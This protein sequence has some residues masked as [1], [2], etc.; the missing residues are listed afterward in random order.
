MPMNKPDGKPAIIMFA[1]PKKK[2]VIAPPS[3]DMNGLPGMETEDGC[4]CCPECSAECDGSCCDQC[5]MA[6]ASSPEDTAEDTAEYGKP[7]A[8]PNKMAMIAKLLKE[9]VK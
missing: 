4:G 7:D 9:I 1:T 6:E 2:P 8:Q 5:D 3:E